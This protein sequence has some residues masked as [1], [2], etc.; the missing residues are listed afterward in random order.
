MDPEVEDRIIRCDEY[1]Y[2]GST[3]VTCDT[4]LDSKGRCPREDHHVE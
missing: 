2:R 1:V 3:Y 4:V